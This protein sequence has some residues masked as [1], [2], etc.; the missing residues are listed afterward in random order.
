MIQILQYRL[1]AGA[2]AALMLLLTSPAFAQKER[3]WR[4]EL[5]IFSH[6]SAQSEEQWDPTPNL[7]YPSAARFLVEPGL[8]E[9]NLAQHHADSMVD[10]FGRQIL[11]ILPQP[12]SSESPQ[13]NDNGAPDPAQSVTD[14]PRDPNTVAITIVEK[15]DE[16]A[17]G[18]GALVPTPFIVL[19]S[20]Q[21]EFR[22]KAAYM[23]RSGKY[24][25]LFHQTWVQPVADQA[26]ALPII[27]DRSGNS[28]QWPP[29]QG[30]IKLYLSRYLH[31]ET[32]L[33]LNTPGDYLPG[34]WRMPPPPLG[35]PS[36][37]IEALPEPELEL[38]ALSG[39]WASAIEQ[40]SSLPEGVEEVPLSEEDLGP[41]YPYRHAI[42]L[43]QERRMRSTEVHYIDHPMLGVVAKLTP[44]TA[45][46]LEAMAQAERDREAAQAQ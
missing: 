8:I 38:G 20:A 33:W 2:V 7:A 3:W 36:L 40:P 27:L 14:I 35:P 42:L 44:L 31:L 21:L 19:P 13:I 22:G 18:Q 23:Q 12:D 10:E 24:R 43:Q 32:N 4:V 9:D 37:I 34:V 1:T 15:I 17:T 25:T 30:S 11:T 45:A 41:V 46:E 28:G 16:Q 6:E 5:L 29:L 26:S 39:D